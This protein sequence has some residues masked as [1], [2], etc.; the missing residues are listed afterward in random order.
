MNETVVLLLTLGGF[1]LVPIALL[2]LC[3]AAPWLRR[4]GAG[5]AKP[6]LLNGLS[7]L[8]LVVCSAYALNLHQPDPLGHLAVYFL[9]PWIST[10]GAL[11]GH[12][13]GLTLIR[14]RDH[15]QEAPPSRAASHH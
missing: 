10:A 14:L 3:F 9:L 15:A 13:L 4:E 11:L 5:V 1:L 7:L 6:W 8:G 2:L 12:G